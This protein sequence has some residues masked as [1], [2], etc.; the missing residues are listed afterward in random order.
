MNLDE[1]L[2][3]RFKRNN[4]NKYLKYLDEWVSGVT[5]EQK[6]YFQKEKERLN[7]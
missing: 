1:Y 4:V 2:I 7:L 3:Y 5:R 6:M